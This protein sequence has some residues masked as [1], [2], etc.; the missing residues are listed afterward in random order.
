MDPSLLRT[1]LCLQYQLVID[2]LEK[3]AADSLEASRGPTLHHFTDN[4]VAWENTLHQLQVQYCLP[5]KAQS[6]S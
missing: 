5:P 3:N 1:I 2:W 6:V 4:T